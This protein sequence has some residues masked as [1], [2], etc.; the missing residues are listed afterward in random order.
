MA[1]KPRSFDRKFI[2]LSIRFD[3]ALLFA[4]QVHRNQDRKKSGI[5]YLDRDGL[6]W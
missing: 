3:H 2:P 4:A 1:S 5:P 6:R